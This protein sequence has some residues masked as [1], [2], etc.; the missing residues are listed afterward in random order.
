MLDNQMLSSLC[1]VTVRPT[2]ADIFS[3]IPNKNI[4]KIR[5]KG[6]L[7]APASGTQWDVL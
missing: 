3:N 6:L 5:L 7:F 1:K 4:L 2:N